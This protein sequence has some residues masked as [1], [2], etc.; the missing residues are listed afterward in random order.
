M[1]NNWIAVIID[2][3]V[4]EYTLLDVFDEQ[5][6]YIAQCRTELPAQNLLF[7]HGKAY[8]VAK[9][10]GYNYIK[11]YSVTITEED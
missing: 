11:V 6:R 2:S 8:G 5:G 9:L 10:D 7:R 1:E 4:A 3:T